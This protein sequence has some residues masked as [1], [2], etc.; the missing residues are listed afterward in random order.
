[1]VPV[2]VPD[3]NVLFGAAS[4]A[5]LIALCQLRHIRLHWSEL[6]LDELARALV[7]TGRQRS[8]E[9]AERNTARMRDAIRDA[10]V[11]VRQVQARFKD[12]APAVKS[13]K[14]LHVAACAAAVLWFRG[15]V[16]SVVLITRN[17]KDFR[18]G[19]LARK[20]ILVTTLDEFL[21]RLFKAQP[22]SVADAF[23]HLRVSFKSRP[24]VDRLLDS[25]LGDGL[26]LTCALLASAADAG[27]I[28]L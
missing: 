7:E 23:H 6:I 13:P 25:L 19:A 14:D 17:L 1:M 5:L 3:A 8:R 2:V 9:T 10:D 12:V 18:A 26:T 4:R 20:R 28:Q 22:L 15:D 16:S 21:V 27:D 11:S 24:S